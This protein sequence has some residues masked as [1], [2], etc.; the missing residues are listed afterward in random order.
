MSS[1]EDGIQL[2]TI[3]RQPRRYYP[4]VP[5]KPFAIAV[6]ETDQLIDPGV[7]A[8]MLPPY[9]VA[10][11]AVA[12][13]N[14]PSLSPNPSSSASARPV[15]I[16]D[17]GVT[18]T[19]LNITAVSPRSSTSTGAATTAKMPPPPPP[20]LPPPPAESGDDALDEN[21][22][23]DEEVLN[24]LGD[25]DGFFA[26]DRDIIVPSKSQ[27]LLYFATATNFKLRRTGG[28]ELQVGA[29]FGAAGPTIDK[30]LG[31]LF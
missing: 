3:V 30:L 23:T 31:C 6:S 25:S 17:V 8:D 12:A 29:A 16:T 21:E 20:P 9:A 15:G 5:R 18:L 28:G 14:G 2:S 10:S 24:A 22:E 26:K 19:P 13:R 7:G 4:V 1:E 11:A 27:V